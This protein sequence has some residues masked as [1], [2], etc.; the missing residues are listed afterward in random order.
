MSVDTYAKDILDQYLNQF[1][2]CS[3][4]FGYLELASEMTCCHNLYDEKC[5][6]EWFKI[7]GSNTCSLCRRTTSYVK[8]I[9]IQRLTDQIPLTCIY[10]VNG[11]NFAS[12]RVDFTSHIAN[13]EY[14]QNQN[15]NHL[16]LEMLDFNLN[17]FDRSNKVM[18][19]IHQNPN[20]ARLCLE[21]EFNACT[22]VIIKS[23]L[24]V[25][26]GDCFTIESRFEDAK[27]VYNTSLQ[28]LITTHGEN[29]DLVICCYLGLGYIGKKF[30]NY[31][32]AISLLQKAIQ[33]GRT[34]GGDNHPVIVSQMISIGDIFRKTD[35]FDSA[36]TS[37]RQAITSYERIPR[38]K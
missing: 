30:G 13:C 4:C 17:F 8:N 2:S 32:E 38:D 34:I 33:I 31:N 27:D 7:K 14:R 19:L 21:K 23:E 29:H 11:C 9:P 6:T 24:S 22:D 12:A 37:Y 16:P 5:I 3:I 15:Q 35:K 25:R 36:E 18:A 1:V 10:K 20:T 26:I 28:S